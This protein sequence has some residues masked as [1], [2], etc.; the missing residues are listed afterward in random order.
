VERRILSAFLVLAV[1]TA[2]CVTSEPLSPSDHALLVTAEKL[3]GFGLE[4]PSEY[5][6][7]ESFKR[8]RFFGGTVMLEYEF[9]M[10]DRAPPFIYSLAELHTNPTNAC[11]SFRA[12]NLGAALGGLSMSEPE[13]FFRYG[14]KSRFGV[15]EHNEVPVGNLFSMC[16][17]RTALLVMFI[18]L[19]F[20][21]AATWEELIRPHLLALEAFE[22]A[23][24]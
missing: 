14:A 24:L 6:Q 3:A 16:H 21:D 20:R 2:A 1:F 22:A 17:S 4:L 7:H 18:G 23:S 15:I 9:E 13:G 12:G 11:H 8:E 10:P 19:H 5:Q